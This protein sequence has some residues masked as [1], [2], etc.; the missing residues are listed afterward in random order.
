MSFDESVDQLLSPIREH[1]AS[2]GFELVD[3]RR[4]GTLDRPI[5]QVRVDRPDSTP[6]H[7]ITAEECGSISRQLE[8][9][10]ESR[11]LV[12]PRY[13]LEVSSPGI[14]RPL[15]W[16]DHW[17][18]YVGRRA[19]IRADGLAGRPEV[20][21]LGVPDDEHVR[22]RLPDGSE[23]TVALRAVRDARLTF[24]WATP[25]KPGNRR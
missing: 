7:G 11:G 24:E 1:I 15:R 21:I 22:L 18:R 9:L 12:G 19:R 23:R 10:L 2:L 3:L 13:V 17:R 4:A 16:P 25:A 20:E 6:G 5:L 14:E 8:R